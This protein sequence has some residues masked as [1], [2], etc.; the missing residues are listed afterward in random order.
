MSPLPGPF[1]RFATEAQWDRAAIGGHAET[2]CVDPDL[3]VDAG[4]IAGCPIAALALSAGGEI[5]L[6]DGEGTLSR[7]AR[8]S[9]E[10]GPSGPAIGPCQRLVAGKERL[11]A[12]TE[13]APRRLVQLD[14]RTLHF[15]AD[16]DAEGVE[17]IASDGSDGLWV[18]AGNELRRI[19]RRGAET[20]ETLALAWA[21]SRVAAG[22]GWIALLSEGGH[23]LFLIDPKS[24]AVTP[25][26]LARFS[27]LEWL[28]TKALSSA[29]GGFLVEGLVKGSTGGE[30]ARFFLVSGGGDLLASG[31]W[32]DDRA[33]DLLAASG[34]DLVGLFVRNGVQNLRRFE[35]LARSGGERRLTPA[36]ETHSP[37]GTWLRAEVKA[38]LPERATLSLRWAASAD[39]GL[40]RA[41]EQALADS[42]RPIAWRLE[43]VDELLAGSWSDRFTYVGTPHEGEVPVECFAF[44]LHQATGPLLWVDLTLSRSGAA[45][46]PEIESLR[47]FHEAES[48]MDDLPAI[49]RGDGDR[50]GT[51]R[52]LVAVLEATTQDIDERIG[53]LA[54]RLDPRRTEERWLPELAAMLGLPFHDALSPAMQLRLVKAAAAILE[55]R[56]T[57][58]GLL[59]LFEALFPDRAVRVADR[60]E[61]LVPITLG[62]G[63]N[64]RRLPALLTGPSMRSPRLNAR[65][66]LG[67]TGLCRTNACADALL[68]PPPQVLVVIPA[69]GNERRRYGDAVAAMAEA[70][71]PAGVRLKLRWAPWRGAARPAG[72]GVL[73]MVD[74]P[75][76]LALGTGPALGRARTGGTTAAAARIDGQG[77]VP[78]RHRLL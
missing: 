39:A 12:L 36:L 41:V 59:A 49:Y 74:A 9:T 3:G 72:D 51:M 77:M 1:Y 73:A 45:A 40:R 31:S 32:R 2:L 54:S 14:S 4:A 11:W 20:G 38:R 13:G 24:G 29:G 7:R 27:D 69:S 60:T 48:L 25:I 57:R 44:P 62:R 63:A 5:V 55:R 6:L 52:R 34:N 30:E 16:L 75:E 43:Q 26:D 76:P 71:L 70:M 68:A 21:G 66:V 19:G 33:P 8:D 10:A 50:D 22:G 61:Q 46:A 58:L 23:R 37:A 53:T 65:L 47:I 42:T 67:R 15:L 28:G 18:L 78:A 17:D 35:G 64:G 56:G